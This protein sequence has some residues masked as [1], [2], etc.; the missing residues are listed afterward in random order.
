MAG[1]AS[2]TLNTLGLDAAASGSRRSFLEGLAA[3]GRRTALG[4]GASSG[5]FAPSSSSASVVSA[6]EKV[7]LDVGTYTLR[8]GFSGDAQPLHREELYGVFG[9]RRS[10]DHRRAV[11][12]R[13]GL[14]LPPATTTASVAPEEND[15]QWQQQQQQEVEVERALLEH[16]RQVYR[17][18]LLVDAKTKK[19]AV[20]VDSRTLPVSVRR[21]LVRVLLGNLRVPQVSFYPRPVV[22]LM[23]CGRSTGLVVDCGFRVTT[24][25]PVYDSRPLMPYTVVTP[26]AGHAV[27]QCVRRLLVRFGQLRR[28]TASTEEKED[29]DVDA[30]LTDSVVA[31][32]VAGLLYAAPTSVRRATADDGHSLANADLFG[33]EM[34]EWYAR[35]TSPPPTTELELALADAAGRRRVLAVPSWVLGRA[36]EILLAGDKP[37]DHMGVVDALVACIAGVPVDTR[38]ALVGGLLVTGGVSQVPNFASRVL[39]DLA[40]ALEGSSRWSALARDVALADCLPAANGAVFNP[41]DRP[42]IGASAAVAARIGGVDIRRDEFDEIPL[43]A[44]LARL[45]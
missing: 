29:D 23:T 7:V 11:G 1:G 5:L 16:V 20:V 33:D 13:H 8:A 9:A 27:H 19:V 37:S 38:R 17:G 32:V 21:A 42:W 3:G 44:L 34:A 22:A 12:Q 45:D 35:N 31:H 18:H 41:A 10:A 14:L 4:V 2:D 24:V 6:E 15:S 28:D 30:M 43:A 40:L 39:E 26:L 25:T 36:T